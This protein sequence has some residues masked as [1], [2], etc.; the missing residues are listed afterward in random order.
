MI[1]DVLSYEAQPWIIDG[2]VWPGNDQEIVRP[3]SSFKKI[4][5]GASLG[6]VGQPLKDI[7]GVGLNLAQPKHAERTAQ[8]K[9]SYSY[10][11]QS[12]QQGLSFSTCKIK[13]GCVIA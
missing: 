12:L 6:L 7:L 13:I 10:P 4:V 3:K 11:I 5:I 2:A 1:A 8:H 9:E